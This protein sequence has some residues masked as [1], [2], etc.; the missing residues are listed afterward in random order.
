MQDPAFGLIEPEDVHT[1]L[2]PSLSG[3]LWMPSCPSGVLTASLSL[4]SSA[5]LL[6]VHLIPLSMSLMKKLNSTGPNMDPQ[7]TPLVTNLHLDIEP[8]TTTLCCSDF[9]DRTEDQIPQQ[10]TDG[11]QEPPYIKLSSSVLKAKHLVFV[12]WT[13][14]FRFHVK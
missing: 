8:L 12:F 11:K 1:G 4:V 10:W 14:H 5:N 6:R 9:H 7:G 2:L 13:E 3:S